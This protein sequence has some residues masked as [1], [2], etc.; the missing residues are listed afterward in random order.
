MNENNSNSSLKHKY[1]CLDKAVS[2]RIDISNIPV[3][4]DPSGEDTV[5]MDS[6][7]TTLCTKY[8]RLV[9]TSCGDVY[10]EFSE[11]NIFPQNI[12]ISR[13]DNDYVDRSSDYYLTKGGRDIDM[14]FQIRQVKFADFTPGKYY[15]SAKTAFPK[16]I[17]YYNKS[18]KVKR[19]KRNASK[20]T[21][22]TNG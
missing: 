5:I 3:Y 15:V 1:S 17:V 11:E 12:K 8:D 22:N 13:R 10:I 18:R 2:N 14:F 20:S 4:L 19:E 21:E 9:I 6:H 16:E 7:G